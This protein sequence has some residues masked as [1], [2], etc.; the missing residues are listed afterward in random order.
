[1]TSHYRLP[2]LLSLPLAA[3]LALGAAGALTIPAVYAR[4]VPLWAAQGMG[5]DWVDLVLVAP[6][7]VVTALLTMRGSRVAALLLAGILVYTLY[8]LALYA[9]F[10]HFGPL[11]LVYTWG[12]GLAFY[13][14]AALGFALHRA[15]VEAWVDPGAPVRL[16]GWVSLLIGVLYSALWLQEAVPAILSG[17]VPRSVT[18]AGLVTN[19]VHVLDLGVVLPAFIVAGVALLRRRAL[20]YWLAPTML[21]FGVLMDVALIAMVVSMRAQRLAA[22]A[23]LGFLVGMTAA[24]G[25]ALVLLLRHVQPASQPVGGSK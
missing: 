16:P 24:T 10:M 9:F 3:L 23:P 12:L 6:M 18:E 2:A 4:E 19:P 11:F 25:A 15:E 5:Q 22:G 14:T 17:R 1:M 8:S 20:G 21:T 7:L 13:A